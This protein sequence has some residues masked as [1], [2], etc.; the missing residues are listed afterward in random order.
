MTALRDAAG[1]HG[2]QGFLFLT[3]D[4]ENMSEA[5][6]AGRRRM[7]RER[8]QKSCGPPDGRRPQL[9][10]FAKWLGL[11]RA[12]SQIAAQHGLLD[13]VRLGAVA[14]GMHLDAGGLKLRGKGRVG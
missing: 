2:R 9:F 8:R 1:T 6:G 4:Q 7:R 3:N 13:V 10:G 14:H 12:R 11:Q 5:A